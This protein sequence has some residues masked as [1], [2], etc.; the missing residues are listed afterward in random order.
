MCVL[1][2]LY[3]CPERLL[4]IWRPNA[5]GSTE[6][7][8]AALYAAGVAGE[9]GGAAGAGEGAAGEGGAGAAECGAAGREG[10]S[11]AGAGE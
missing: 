1:M 5:G 2:L 7:Q 11:A 9:G 8:A 3:M 4:Y 6:R 10:E